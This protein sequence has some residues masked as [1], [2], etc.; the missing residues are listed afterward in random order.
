MSSLALASTKL[1]AGV[2]FRTTNI[3]SEDLDGISAKICTSKY[4]PLYGTITCVVLVC[5]VGVLIVI[6]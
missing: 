4:S 1:S 2:K 5:S 3:S 6:N